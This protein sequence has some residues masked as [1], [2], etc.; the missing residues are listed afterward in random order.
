MKPFIPVLFALLFAI[1]LNV[2]LP[3]G[4][5]GQTAD[6]DT[7]EPETSAP[8]GETAPGIDL[9]KTPWLKGVNI[10]PRPS[11]PAP[12]LPAEIVMADGKPVPATLTEDVTVLMAVDSEIFGERPPQEWNGQALPN[13]AWAGP[14]AV[15]WFFDD[16][17]R[18]QSTMASCSEPLPAN[19]MKVTPL[20]PTRLGGVTVSI[21]RPL[22]Y[23]ESPGKIR[24][25]FANAS[26][27]LNVRVTDITPPTCG[28]EITV[29]KQTGTFWCAENPPHG[30]PLPKKA[31]VYLKGPLCSAAGED[32]QVVVSDLELGAK[33]VLT[34]EQGAVRLP[35]TGEAK[36][37]VILQDNDEVD[38]KTVRTGLCELVDGAPVPVPGTTGDSFD[39]SKIKLPAHPYLFVDATDLSGNRQVLCVPVLVK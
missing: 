16:I 35:R 5:V 23:E 18:N 31:D 1:A 15:N 6:D 3:V 38:G 27:G 12:V 30:Y 19:Q 26:R 33:M 29:G 4:A 37:K 39:L 32:E 13:A 14:A 36:I 21:A 8:V 22:T 25:V 7:D 20:D 10:P 34:A 28:L 11:Y 2:L 17:G 9:D 24:K